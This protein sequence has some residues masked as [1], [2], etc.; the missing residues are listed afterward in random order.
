MFAWLRTERETTEPNSAAR[1]TVGHASAHVPAFV[2]T[3]AP[4]GLDDENLGFLPAQG[5]FTAE[6]R[7]LSPGHA[8]LAALALRELYPEG[9]P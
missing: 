3:N 7:S 5:F 1:G 6:K 8:E 9:V 4:P 2:T